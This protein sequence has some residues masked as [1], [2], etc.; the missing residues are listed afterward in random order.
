MSAYSFGPHATSVG[1]YPPRR[2]G[3]FDGFQRVQEHY[4]VVSDVGWQYCIVDDF[5]NLV[6]ICAPFECL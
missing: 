1:L 2:H 4:L 5:G 6:A 3:L